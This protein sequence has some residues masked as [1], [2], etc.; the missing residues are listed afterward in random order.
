VQSEHVCDLFTAFGERGVSSERVAEL[1]CA[2]VRNYLASGTAVGPY[3]ADQ[4]LLPLA[5]AGAG[6]F[7][8]QTPSEHARSNAA[9]IEKFLPVQIDFEELGPDCWRI[10]AS[11]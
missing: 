6:S 7:T 1:V 5:L 8:T 4:L 2:E 9:L 11:R 3:L 10:S